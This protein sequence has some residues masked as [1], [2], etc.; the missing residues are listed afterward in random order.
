MDSEK[1]IKPI[2]QCSVAGIQLLARALFT[3]GS[4]L[5][6]KVV[7]HWSGDKE[8]CIAYHKVVTQGYQVVYLLTFEY[9]KPY[10]FHSFP[11]MELQSN[12]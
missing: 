4:E 6:M 5:K 10:V 11:M 7:V 3:E 1:I 9:M 2:T 8:C 12:T